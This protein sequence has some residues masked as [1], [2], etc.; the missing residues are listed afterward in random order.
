[1]TC[2]MYIQVF[3]HHCIIASH[4]IASHRIALQRITSHHIASH[5]SALHCSAVPCRTGYACGHTDIHA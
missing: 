4:R 1:M 2:Y 5:Y 3:I